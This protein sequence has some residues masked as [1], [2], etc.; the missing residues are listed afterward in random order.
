M[1]GHENII[2]MRK[3]G[4]AP[5]CIFVNDFVCETNPDITGRYDL[6]SL[7]EN[8]VIQLQDWRFTVGL[9]VSCGSPSEVRAKA[10]L[11]AIKAAGAAVVGSV[12]SY[13]VPG[14]TL[15]RSGW[16]EI[17]KKEDAHASVG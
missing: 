7:D 6:V 14:M 5:R 3:A 8:D 15:H 17:W 2:A 9:T 12:H 1:K 4:K 13:Q 16:A 10:L 11:D